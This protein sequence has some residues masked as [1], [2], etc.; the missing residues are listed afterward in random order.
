MVTKSFPETG[1]HHAGTPAAAQLVG[2]ISSANDTRSVNSLLAC[3][4]PPS[5][6]GS[7]LPSNQTSLEFLP[8]RA[9]NMTGPRGAVS[10]CRFLPWPGPRPA[11][12]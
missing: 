4:G 12:P 11:T 5:P 10:F 1:R 6:L 2:I 7:R 8:C 9:G 3:Y